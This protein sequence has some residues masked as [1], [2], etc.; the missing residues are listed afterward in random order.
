MKN[1]STT[2][3]KTERSPMKLEDLWSPVRDVELESIHDAEEIKSN[4]TYPS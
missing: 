2:M 4:T 1:N 3:L